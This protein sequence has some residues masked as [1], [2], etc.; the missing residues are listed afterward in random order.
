MGNIMAKSATK[1]NN[2]A[3]TIMVVDDEEPAADIIGQMLKALGYKTEIQLNPVKALEIFKLRPDSFDLVMTDMIMPHMTG[4]QLSKK[5][6]AIRP[7]I[8]IILCTGYSSLIDENRARLIG[9]AAY[10]TKPVALSEI[11]KTVK[12]ILDE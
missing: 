12:M 2:G 10:L 7:N 6:K 8:P 5:L 9:I 4:A 11:S 1:A 3:V